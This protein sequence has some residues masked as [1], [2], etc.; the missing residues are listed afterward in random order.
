MIYHEYNSTVSAM[1]APWNASSEYKV[2]SQTPATHDIILKPL[3]SDV[4]LGRSKACFNH[5][6]NRQFRLI[7]AAYFKSYRH[8]PNQKGQKMAFVSGIL[9]DL[10]RQNFRFLK[11]CIDGSPGFFEVDD[12]TARDKVA[13]AIRDANTCELKKL[14]KVTLKYRK[15]DVLTSSSSDQQQHQ[16]NQRVVLIGQHHD[17]ETDNDV[18]GRAAAEHHPTIVASK[19][20]FSSACLLPTSN[21]NGDDFHG[22]IEPIPL[23]SYI[24][25][26]SISCCRHDTSTVLDDDHD[27]KDDSEVLD[28]FIDLPL[29][30]IMSYCA[31]LRTFTT[32]SQQRQDSVAWTIHQN[33]GVV[34]DFAA[35]QVDEDSSSLVGCSYEEVPFSFSVEQHELAGRQLREAKEVL[36][37]ATLISANHFNLDSSQS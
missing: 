3:E 35:G 28:E 5:E 13:H 14:E 8:C 22:G 32:D 17:E 24:T 21:Y 6:G 11:P 25:P 33:A 16:S 2:H 29:H 34:L 30:K 31:R 26:D 20:H 27:S 23:K 37:A 1:Q 10:R 4:I 15:P 7:I 19:G 9:D 12:N 18:E 36:E